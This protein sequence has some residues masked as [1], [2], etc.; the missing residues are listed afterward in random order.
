MQAPQYNRGAN[1]SEAERGNAGGRSTVSTSDVDAELDKVSTSINALTANAALIQ[2]DDGKLRDQVVDLYALTPA[3]RAALQSKFTP[4]GLWATATSY[5]ANDL[6]E[7]VGVAYICAVAHTSTVFATD[8]AAGRWQI[9][10]A[11]ATAAAST[12]APTSTL[13]STNTQAAIEELDGD[14]R[15]AVNPQFASL[16]GGL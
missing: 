6:V 8:A 14:M 5:A 15:A 10:V 11:S 4:R 16:Y 12:F 9:F 3:A 1:F 13:S 7:F 2:R